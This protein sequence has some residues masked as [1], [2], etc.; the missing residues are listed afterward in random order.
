MTWPISNCTHSV[1]QRLESCCEC[2]YSS[3]T[4]S[5]DKSIPSQS[6][7]HS[8]LFWPHAL[9]HVH[10]YC[11]MMGALIYLP[12]CII[13]PAQQRCYIALKGLQAAVSR[14][15]T[16]ASI[17]LP[18]VPCMSTVWQRSKPNQQRCLSWSAGYLRRVQSSM[19]QRFCLPL[20]TFTNRTS[21]IET[22][23]QVLSC[24]ML[25]F[26]TNARQA[27]KGTGA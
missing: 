8:L 10:L 20:S 22:W 2:T 15:A 9:S 18:F 26:K 13:E 1:N 6:C 25:P 11:I 27:Q 21:F 17:V 7:C 19:Q 3:L 5:Y 4:V 16:W 24:F 12:Q 14:F 23:R